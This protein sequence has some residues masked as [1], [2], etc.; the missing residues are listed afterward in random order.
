MQLTSQ[1]F[2][3][4]EHIPGEFAF[5][6]PN[7]ASHIAL[8]SNTNPHLTWHD[9]PAGTQS[10]VLVCH[11]PDVPSKADDVN[12]EGKEVPASLP[13][14]TFYHWLLLDIPANLSEIAAGS[15]SNS[16]TP[17]G[18]AGPEASNGLRHGINDYTLWFAGDAQM[19]GNYFGYDG[20]CPPWNDT[21]V[22]HYTF[23]LYALDTPK[24]DVQGSLTGPNVVQAL[25]EV[26]VLAQA[27]ITGLYSLNPD[28]K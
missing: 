22:H 25:K 15:H 16:V 21:I 11:D 8:S 3:D 19:T 26:N 1:S 12:Q 20:P 18:K 9:A 23:T 17:Q 2:R 6:V 28:V 24:L 14:I 13:R 5:A 4:G 27:S 10:F 7:A